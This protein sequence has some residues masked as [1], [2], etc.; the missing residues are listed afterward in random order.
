MHF[1]I[2]LIFITFL[3]IF[4]FI[5]GSNMVSA[6]YRYRSATCLIESSG[7]VIFSGKCKVWLSEDSGGSFSISNAIDGLPLI[8]KQDDDVAITDVSVYTDEQSCEVSGLTTGGINSRWGEA[9][10]ST[11]QEGC[12]VGSDFK[13]C[14]YLY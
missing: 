2:R 5:I 8:G 1:T 6:E 11:E 14:Y 12:W 13:I 3:I 4:T 10:K 9:S 7:E